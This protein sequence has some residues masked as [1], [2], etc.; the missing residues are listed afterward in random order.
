MSILNKKGKKRKR[1]RKEK[2]E[3]RK[4]KRQ[5][6]NRVLH[7]PPGSSN[8]LKHTGRKTKK[9]KKKRKRKEKGVI[10]TRRTKKKRRMSGWC[11]QRFIYKDVQKTF[12]L[13]GFKI[14][15]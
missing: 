9:K 8:I 4:N 13:M 1:K 5:K 2:E 15:Q 11:F 10:E 12:Q 7:S 3:K 14:L 6:T